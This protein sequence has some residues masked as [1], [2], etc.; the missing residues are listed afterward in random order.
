MVGS[1]DR[2]LLP[3]VTV[4]VI[5]SLGAMVLQLMGCDA[6]EPIRICKP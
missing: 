2:L 6:G 5:V 3:A 1:Y 4:W